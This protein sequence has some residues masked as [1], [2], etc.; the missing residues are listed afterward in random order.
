[1][2]CFSVFPGLITRAC[3]VWLESKSN[4]ASRASLLNITDPIIRQAPP[5]QQRPYPSPTSTGRIPF[6]SSSHVNIH[7]ETWY[8]CYGSLKA[9]AI[10]LIVLHGGPGATHNYVKTLSLLSVGPYSRPVILY[11]QIGCGNS[12]RFRELRED[13]SFWQPQLFIDELNNLVAHLGI[14]RFDVLGQSWGGMLGAQYATTRP[15]GLRKLVIADSPADMS[16]WVA[17]A[18]ELRTLLP[19]DVQETLNR[20]EEEGST[21]SEEYETAMLEFYKWFVVRVD[22]IPKEFVETMENLKEDDTVYYTM[23]SEHI[24]KYSKSSELMRSAERP[25]RIPCHR[26]LEDLGHQT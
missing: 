25:I 17:V 6:S 11:D 9:D 15:P 20:C 21:D 8:A 23:V 1:M 22:P 13:N 19:K 26:K 10:P 3:C 16:T 2:A 14:K 18:N 4:M 5:G 7:S 12:T 24:T